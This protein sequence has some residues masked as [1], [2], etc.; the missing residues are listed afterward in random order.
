MKTNA[1]QETSMNTPSGVSGKS[2][3]ALTIIRFVVGILFIFSGLI[4]ANDPS[5]LAF[6]MEDFFGLWGM[7]GLKDYSMIL[8]LIMITF[9]IIAGVAL[10]IGYKFKLFSFLLL[11]LMIFFMFL[12][13]YAVVYEAR[14]G[15][16][17]KCGCFG[18]C[19]PLTAW[20]SFWKDVI[21]LILV[22]YLFLKRNQI[23]SYLSPKMAN[24]TMLAAL[25]VVVLIQWIA[26]RYLPFVDCLPFKKGRNMYYL[27]KES[28]DQKDSLTTNFYYEIDGKK[29]KKTYEE[30]MA[31]STLWSKDPAEIENIVVKKAP[32]SAAIM[33]SFQ[34]VDKNAQQY[35]EDIFKSESAYFIFFIRGL[36]DMNQ[37]NIDKI[38]KI[39]DDLNIDQKAG[40]IAITSDPVDLV[41]KYL[42]DHGMSDIQIFT[43]D[44]VNIK[45]AIRSNPGLMLMQ[46]GLILG[47]WT[48]A[49]Y[50]SEFSFEGDLIKVK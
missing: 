40:I 23:Q 19:I 27:Y 48:P 34:I 47:K 29:V 39:Y 36:E 43:L 22:I 15:T 1:T 8:S 11:L 41:Q 46:G 17:L 14:T 33:Q 28:L 37:S 12:T 7:D 25:V 24:I 3:T 31:D 32:A 21:L 20:Q 26:L 45:I 49:N 16:E 4:K 5:G 38:K 10:L 18:D 35:Q 44:E 2:T 50:P 13:T 30:Y 9:E 42:S 6:K